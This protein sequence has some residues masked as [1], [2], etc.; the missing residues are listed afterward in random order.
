M[1]H[2]ATYADSP[3]EHEPSSCL[4]DVQAATCSSLPGREVF[5]PLL[6]PFAIT[7]LPLQDLVFVSQSI[8][9]PIHLFRLLRYAACGSALFLVLV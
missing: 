9:T 1:N 7:F 8:L 5:V 6:D 3:T 4:Q 2:A